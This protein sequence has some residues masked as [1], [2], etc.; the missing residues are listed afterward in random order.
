MSTDP[1]DTPRFEDALNAL[2][3]HVVKLESGDVPLDE[4]LAL[5]E[6]G[7]ALAKDCNEQLDA[8]QERV[9]ALTRGP[10]GPEQSPL[11]E[12]D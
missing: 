7:I 4:A 12:P 3:E 5:F 6:A 11:P 8:A 10:A 2:E 1:K 9:L